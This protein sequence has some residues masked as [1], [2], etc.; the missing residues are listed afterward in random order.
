M[1]LEEN[2]KI[3]N[4]QDKSMESLGIES[5]EMEPKEKLEKE[6]I[7]KAHKL[8]SQRYPLNYLALTEVFTILRPLSYFRK[9][10]ESKKSSEKYTKLV[11]S[12][13]VTDS[14]TEDNN[15][16]LKNLTNKVK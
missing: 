3:Q 13:A 7:D 4:L 12:Q 6:E 14:L 1:D 9:K 10:N 8:I 16:N 11:T 5:L 15:S 2:K